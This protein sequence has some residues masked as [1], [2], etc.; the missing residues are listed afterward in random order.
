VATTEE[1]ARLS[2][3]TVV[4]GALALTDADGLEGLTIRRLAQ[5][6]G[7]T[8]MALYWHFKNKD[9]LLDAVADRLWSL[10]DTEVDQHRPW[11][12]RLRVLMESMVEV[13]R[14]HPPAASLMVT[15][16][17]DAAVHCFDIMEV[18]LGVFAD[19]GFSAAEGAALCRHGLRTVTT[20]AVGDPGLTP[21]QTEEE[22]AEF[23]RRK[24]IVLETLPRTRYPHLVEA[25]GPL[26]EQEGPETS[27][28]FGIELFVAGVE[29][30]AARH[31]S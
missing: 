23:I 15:T 7:V 20:L 24:R 29:A 22:V 6:L 8:P 19:A 1:R 30:L 16:Q 10:I 3:E 17:P 25:A 27:F 5:H 26:S 2:R 21:R 28:A 9:E 18:A 31:E 4:D 13:L 12:E 11:P 14:A